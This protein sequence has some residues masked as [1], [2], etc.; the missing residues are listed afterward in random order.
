MRKKLVGI[1][2]TVA[3]AAGMTGCSIQNSAVATE[4]K[5][6]TDSETKK[7]SEIKE[8]VKKEENTDAKGTDLTLWIFLNPESTEDPRN[9]VLKEIVE[10]YNETNNNGKHSNCREH[11]L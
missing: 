9:V 7:E 3:L 10:E 4:E 6:Q 5:K 2:C 1:L 11:S 8:N